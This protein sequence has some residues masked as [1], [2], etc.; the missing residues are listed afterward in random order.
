MDYE[1]VIQ[2]VYIANYILEMPL[3]GAVK[4]SANQD[5]GINKN[6]HAYLRVIR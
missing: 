5:M 1:S 2:I 4:F 3:N 6:F